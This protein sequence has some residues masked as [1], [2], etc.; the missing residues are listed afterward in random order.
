[1]VLDTENADTML[2]HRI[3]TRDGWVAAVNNICERTSKLAH[4][5]KGGLI[6]HRDQAGILMTQLF[7]DVDELHI[8]IE[9]PLDAITRSMGKAMGLQLTSMFKTC[10]D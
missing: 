4:V 3:K 6:I 5:L 7:K 10:E 9:N 1:M 2:D 8:E